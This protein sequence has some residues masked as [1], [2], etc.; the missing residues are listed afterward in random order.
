MRPR[1]KLENA[2]L[3]LRERV[4]HALN[5]LLE[6]L[7]RRCVGRGHGGEVRDEVSEVTVLLLA[8]RRL[9]ADRLLA[10]LHDLAH[11]LRAH[12]LGAFRDADINLAFGGL[13]LELVAKLADDLVA[14]HASRDL[15]H[16]RLATEFLE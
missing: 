1:A 13:A 16:V 8:D 3:S 5:L 2:T 11:L 14:A 15:L 4:Q 9:E 12:G 10:D 7:M 6:E